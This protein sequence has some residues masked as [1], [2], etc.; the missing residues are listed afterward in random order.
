MIKIRFVDGTGFVSDFIKF[1]T[2]G[3]WSHVDISSHL[4]ITSTLTHN[5]L[6]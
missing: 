3:D 2:W 1:W 4:Y 6:S 5:P